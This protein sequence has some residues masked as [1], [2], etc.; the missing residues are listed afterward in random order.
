MAI[1]QVLELCLVALGSMVRE[2]AK[3]FLPDMKVAGHAETP[4]NWA[5]SVFCLP[6]SRWCLGN[7]GGPAFASPLCMSLSGSG[8]AGPA[9]RIP[10]FDHDDRRRKPSSVAVNPDAAWW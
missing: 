7:S 9:P 1:K 4:L 6:I 10:L 8:G 3:E 5:K 2:V